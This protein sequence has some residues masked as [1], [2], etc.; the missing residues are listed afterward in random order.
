MN[1]IGLI[2][3]ARAALYMCNF[4]SF[5]MAAFMVNILERIL[6]VELE[7]SGDEL[8]IGENSILISNHVT[9][10]DFLCIIAYQYRKGMCGHGKFMSKTSLK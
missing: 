4:A 9:N 7:F 3:D 5:T 6:G 2:N 1:K 8:P 10:V